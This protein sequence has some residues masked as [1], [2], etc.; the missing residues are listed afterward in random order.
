MANEFELAIPE[1]SHIIDAI[2]AY[3]SSCSN[4]QWEK[5]LLSKVFSF[6]FIAKRCWH[7]KIVLG[8]EIKWTWNMHDWTLFKFT[9]IEEDCK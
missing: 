9:K 5:L 1:I 6:D 8:F 3:F 2:D 4:N 7:K